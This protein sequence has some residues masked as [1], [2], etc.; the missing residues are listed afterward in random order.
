MRDGSR[1]E[2][3]KDWIERTAK[4]DRIAFESL[5]EVYA[6][7]IFRFVVRMTRC[8]ELAE[9]LVNDVMVQV[10]KSAARY[11]GRSKPSTWVF[12][13]ARLRTLM[14]LRRKRPEACELHETHI[15]NANGE[16]CPACTQVSDERKTQARRALDDLGP[17]HR[18]VVE[19]AFFAGLS[20]PEIAAALAVPVNTIKS[21]MF[22]VKKRLS[23]T[24]AHLVE[25]PRCGACGG[26]EI[27]C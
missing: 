27:A 9:D 16:G 15:S 13:I 18:E 1:V 17:L 8:E 4:G 23:Q 26:F 2:I 7:A 22:Q 6:P 24:L 14:A 25:D 10:W 21:R 11:E 20:Y 3:E 19:L 12:G 5:Y